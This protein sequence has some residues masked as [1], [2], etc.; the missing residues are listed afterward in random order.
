MTWDDWMTATKPK[1]N[2]TWNLHN[3]LLDASLDFFWL[4]S[5]LITAIDQ[6]GQG[7][8]MASNTFMEA[9]CQY[10]HSL[11]LPASVLNICAIEGVGF[12]AE[13]P[14][15]RRNVKAQGL[16]FLGERE[17]L[18]MVELGMRGDPPALSAAS[19]SSSPPRAWSNSGQIFMGLRSEM[20]LDDPS[21]RT[22]WRR[23][24]R[25]GTYHNDAPAAAAA[26][27]ELSAVKQFLSRLAAEHDE[28]GGEAV[29]A[30]LDQQAT[31]EFIAL[32]TGRKIYDF[33]LQPEA[34]VDINLSLQQIGLDSLM[35]IEL[36]RWFRQ[37]FGLQ[38]SVLE[39]MNTPSLGQLGVVVAEK[40]KEKLLGGK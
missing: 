14:I 35:A 34:E 23:D 1:V 18:D 24:R 15:A 28:Q 30:L 40:L 36:R 2:G 11:G 7:N 37:A 6:P 27:Q 4:A 19:P 8:Y 33:M 22:N 17:F 21:N 39:V 38:I 9:F 32:E 25:M 13:N 31:T 12:V 10:R 5:S 26:A 20:H 3:G 16:Y 29:V